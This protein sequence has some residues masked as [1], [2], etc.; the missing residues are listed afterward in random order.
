MIMTVGNYSGRVPRRGNDSMGRW[1][2]QCLAGK[3]KSFVVILAYQPCRQMLKV[4]NKI[5]TL[6]VTAQHQSMLSIEKRLINSRKAFVADLDCFIK[7]CRQRGEG[8][9]LL[10]D[11]NE[12]LT[13]FNSTMKKIQVN[14]NLRDLMWKTCGRDDFSTCMTGT[15]IIDFTLADD[16]IVECVERACYEPFK[17][18]NKGDHHTLLINFDANQLFGNTT[19]DIINPLRREFR[20]TDKKAVQ[21]YIEDRY[22]FL[23]D[24]KFA[25]RIEKLKNNWN[26]D[27][28]ESLDRDHIR[29]CKQAANKAKRKPNIA[30]TR[31]LANLRAC[32]FFRRTYGHGEIYIYL[33]C[34]V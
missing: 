18:R 21:L 31:K 20:S 5:S 10:G 11:F 17:M 2:Y 32:L 6:T 26:P 22:K 30:F 34:T 33:L 28:A 14:N 25:E 19:H 12:S 16:W 3:T 4:G 24:H 8:I 23:H 27:L 9:L 15:K 7:Q 29:A 13:D 1:S